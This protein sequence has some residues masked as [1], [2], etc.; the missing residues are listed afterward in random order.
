MVTMV[1]IGLYGWNVDCG[2]CKAYFMYDIGPCN[3]TSSVHC[4]LMYS[5]PGQSTQ[6]HSLT[7][8]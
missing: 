1:T 3:M 2:A 4:I 7:H 6:F 5:I 8:V